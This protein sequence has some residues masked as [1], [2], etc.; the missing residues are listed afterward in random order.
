MPSK[1]VRPYKEIAKDIKPEDTA[2]VLDMICA[3][4]KNSGGR[5]CTYSNTAEGLAAFK[6]NAQGYFSYLHSANDKLDEREKLIPDIEG[7]T[8]YL[9]IDRSTL[10][11]Y[12]D[13]GGEWAATIDYIKNC[14]GY[15]KK[16]LALKGK[17]P[18][19][20][21]IFDMTN[22]HQY[23]NTNSFVLEAK[24][25]ENKES[26]IVLESQARAAGL[27]WNETTKDWEPEEG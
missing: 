3:C 27:I 26:D 5:P 12:H 2:A 22:N 4:Y 9:G 17:I 23:Y 24:I 10:S 13:R 6:E 14:I 8:L 20:M 19:V 21:A 15:A 7:L 1:E 11:R 18:T 25:T 16:Q